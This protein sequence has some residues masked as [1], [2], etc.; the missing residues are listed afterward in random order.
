ME[1]RELARVVVF[2][3]LVGG[4]GDQVLGHFG[5]LL[6]RIPV[7]ELVHGLMCGCLC[8]FRVNIVV[9]QVFA[10]SG[11]AKKDAVVAVRVALGRPS[12]WLLDGNRASKRL[13]V[14]HVGLSAVPSLKWSFADSIMIGSIVEVTGVHKGVCPELSSETGAV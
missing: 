4:D 5:S 13:D 9:D 10:G 12:A 8:T 2:R 7:V 11:I 3:G 6:C 14:A 1:G